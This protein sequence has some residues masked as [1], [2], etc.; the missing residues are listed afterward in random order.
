MPQQQRH[1]GVHGNGFCRLLRL[2]NGFASVE[3]IVC[4]CG[5]RSLHL[6][7][8]Q[9]AS[10][11]RI[12]CSCGTRSL[13]LHSTRCFRLLHLVNG[14]QYRQLFIARCASGC[15]DVEKCAC[16]CGAHC[17][18]IRE[19]A[20]LL[21]CG[22]LNWCARSIASGA[23][24]RCNGTASLCAVVAVGHSVAVRQRIALTGRNCETGVLG[25]Q[26]LALAD[27][28]C[29]CN[30]RAIAPCGGAMRCAARS[31]CQRQHA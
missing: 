17:E 26:Q 28:P 27:L 20:S 29:S 6:W 8:A 31:S 16:V 7:C 5:A 10:V 12:V 25:N 19:P 30:G 22:E 13:H 4:I 23:G 14:A 15:T 9:L 2:A 18:P 24:S 21:A 1:G 3:R 11:E